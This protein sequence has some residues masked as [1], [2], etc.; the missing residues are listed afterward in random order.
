ME[1]ENGVA[2]GIHAVVETMETPGRDGPR[3]GRLRVAQRS[4]KLANRDNAVLALRQRCQRRP[5]PLRGLLS[6]QSD[7]GWKLNSARVSPPICSLFVPLCG[8]A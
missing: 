3:D 6:F 7:S 4:L 2:D 8:S 1:V 5:R